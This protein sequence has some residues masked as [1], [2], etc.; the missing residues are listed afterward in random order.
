VIA[1]FRRMQ[2]LTGEQPPEPPKK[3]ESG[4]KPDEP[5]NKG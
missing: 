1:S 4:D 3:E 2:E 5:E